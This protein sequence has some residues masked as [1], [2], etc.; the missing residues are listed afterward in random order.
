MSVQIL[1]PFFNWT[2]WGAFVY[3][4]NWVVCVFHMFWIL[5]P[6]FISMIGKYFLPFTMSPFILL[7]V[8][9]VVQK[10]FSLTRS[11]LLI[12][13][14]VPSAF[15]VRS[16]NWLPRLTSKAYRLC[17]LLGV[18]QFQV[19]HASLQ[20]FRVNFCIWGKIDVQFYYFAWGCPVFP[21]PFVEKTVFP[22]CM[23]LVPL[24]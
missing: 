9:T 24:S 8:S 14:F 20:S 23:F 1:C 16:K 11:R 4:W 19:L 2:A 22:C 18:T 10:R 3:F 5:K 21:T 7:M 13:A 17:F 15:G 12:L 6:I